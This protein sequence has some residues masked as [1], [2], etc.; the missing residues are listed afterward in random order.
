ML[1]AVPLSK[2]LERRVRLHQLVPRERDIELLRQLLDSLG[3]M[4]ATGIGEEDEGIPTFV[5]CWRISEA[6]GGGVSEWSKTLSMMKANPAPDLALA[7]LFSLASISF[8]EKP[9]WLSLNV[10]ISSGYSDMFAVACFWWVIDMPEN[11]SW[12]LG[13]FGQ[14]LLRVE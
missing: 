4:G 9:G 2:R 3:L 8:K 5:R 13:R 10:V 6:P 12:R 14:T 11:L 1:S 7:L